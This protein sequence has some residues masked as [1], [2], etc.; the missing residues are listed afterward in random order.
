MLVPSSFHQQPQT[1]ATSLWLLILFT[2][3]SGC[4]A[5]QPDVCRAAME[6]LY[7]NGEIP[8]GEEFTLLRDRYA[9]CRDDPYLRDDEGNYPN[10]DATLDTFG[11]GGACWDFYGDPYYAS[12]EEACENVLIEDCFL[13]RTS[14]ESFCTDAIQSTDLALNCEEFLD[15]FDP[16]RVADLECNY[17]DPE[18]EGISP[19]PDTSSDG[20][21]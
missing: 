17:I 21:A 9:Q 11:P 12:C 6:C 10:R 8:E 5:P 4:S 7:P 14:G 1:C 15:G 16:R 20:G 18:N 3:G 2:L 19:I 13:A